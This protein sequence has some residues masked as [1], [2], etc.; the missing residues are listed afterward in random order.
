VKASDYIRLF[1]LRHVSTNSNF[2]PKQACLMKVKGLLW[3]AVLLIDYP[4]EVHWIISASHYNRQM[5]IP[6]YSSL[7]A[8]QSTPQNFQT[9]FYWHGSSTSNHLH[10]LHSGYITPLSSATPHYWLSILCA[11]SSSQPHKTLSIFSRKGSWQ[12]TQHIS[13]PDGTLTYLLHGAESFLRS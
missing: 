9:T 8:G 12:L 13:A 1:I 11:S 2:L 6:L 4:V 10:T 5:L 7:S 3:Q